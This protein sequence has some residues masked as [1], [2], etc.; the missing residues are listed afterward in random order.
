VDWLSDNKNR[1]QHL[2]AQTFSTR[3]RGDAE[4]VFVTQ[5]LAS[6]NKQLIVTID[7]FCPGYKIWWE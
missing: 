4:A 5:Q 6:D 1:W 2:A 7:R 3:H